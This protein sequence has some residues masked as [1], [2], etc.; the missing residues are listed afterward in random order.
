MV[1]PPLYPEELETAR[2]PGEPMVIGKLV[3]VDLHPA[4]RGTW[5]DLEG[6]D[7]VWIMSFQTLTANC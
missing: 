1:L 4:Q 3:E 2:M 6:G 5:I 7:R